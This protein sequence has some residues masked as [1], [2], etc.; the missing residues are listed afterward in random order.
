[1]QLKNKLSNK[2]LKPRKL[3]IIVLI[4]GFGC[5]TMFSFLVLKSNLDNL[6]P[7]QAGQAQTS[8]ETQKQQ[9]ITLINEERQKFNLGRL[10]QNSNLTQAADNKV[11]DMISGEY[12]AHVSPTGKKW[13]DFIQ[14]S[15]YNYVA[16][17]E[18]LA[19]NYTSSREIVQAWLNS[20]AHRDNILNP[21][22]K[23]TGI[24][25]RSSIKNQIKNIYIVQTFGSL[26]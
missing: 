3:A 6:L 14:A 16:G 18:N 11:A 20:P 21:K 7:A 10:R 13:S 5:A 24:A 9:I 23:E 19:R 12:F 17:G 8:E 2:L 22:F 1:M 25:I 4:L 15:G 26:D